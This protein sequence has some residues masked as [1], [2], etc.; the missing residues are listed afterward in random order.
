MGTR[1]EVTFTIDFNPPKITNDVKIV[2]II[3]MI[4]YHPKFPISKNSF[5]FNTSIYDCVN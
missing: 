4:S 1:P 2:N 3:P 5:G